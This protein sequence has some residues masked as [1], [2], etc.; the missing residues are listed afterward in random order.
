MASEAQ[1]FTIFK[2]SMPTDPLHCCAIHTQPVHYALDTL[3]KT[4]KSFVQSVQYCMPEEG[5]TG[6]KHCIKL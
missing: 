5:P 1:I 4:D 2:E 6:P 3:Y